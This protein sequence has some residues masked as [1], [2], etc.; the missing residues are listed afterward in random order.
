[1]LRRNHPCNSPWRQSW[2]KKRVYSGKDLWNW[3]VLRQ[4]WTSKW[5]RG[6]KNGESTEEDDVIGI[7]RSYR[8]TD[9]ESGSRSLGWC[10]AREAG[11][12]FQRHDAVYW[13]E[14]LVI[15]NEDDVGGRA[16]VTVDAERVLWGHWEMRL[17]ESERWLLLAVWVCHNK[18]CHASWK[19]ICWS[20]RWTELF[21]I[22][23]CM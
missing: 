18:G 19:L 7:R 12:W 10:W 8:Q 5:V 4:E 15:H 2:R 1:L 11:S 21:S 17:C 6:N 9:R 3:W 16:W 14:W 20:M 23:S 13:K 22:L